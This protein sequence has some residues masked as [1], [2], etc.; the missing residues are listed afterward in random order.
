MM[1]GIR[2]ARSGYQRRSL[3]RG[4]LRGIALLLALW[5]AMS[6][7]GCR[8]S[9]EQVKAEREA[10]ER[11]RRQKIVVSD[12][13]RDEAARKYDV[14]REK[15]FARQYRESLDLLDEVEELDPST[16]LKVRLFRDRMA[17]DMLMVSDVLM[18]DGDI[19]SAERILEMIDDKERFSKYY[20]KTQEAKRRLAWFKKGYE[21]LALG[22]RN[23]DSHKITEGINLLTEVVNEYKNT[24]LADKAADI[25]RTLGR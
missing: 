16:D 15:G 25:L 10:K 11:A 20:S 8:K 18:E 24:R 3:V 12:Q 13:A 21:K 2:I 19:D 4:S 22:K 14:A 7:S 17:E 23:I 9:D 1:G 6:V 5:I